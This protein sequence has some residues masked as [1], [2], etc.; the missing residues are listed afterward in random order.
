MENAISRVAFATENSIFTDIGQIKFDPHTLLPYFWQLIFWQ[1][2]S[3]LSIHPAFWIFDKKL[4][5]ITTFFKIYYRKHE[6]K[7]YT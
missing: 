4:L 3:N 5:E 1:I 6:M 2:L 7:L